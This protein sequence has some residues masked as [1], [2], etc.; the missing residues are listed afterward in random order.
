[1]DESQLYEPFLESANK[2]IERIEH[3]YGANKQERDF[4]SSVQ[5]SLEV[6]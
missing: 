1:L 2:N 5:D 6:F 3:K 4:Q